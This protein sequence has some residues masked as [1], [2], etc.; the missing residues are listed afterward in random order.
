M[1]DAGS[2]CTL[3][4][5]Q[6]NVTLTVRDERVLR[7]L[8]RDNHE[9]DD[10]WL[11]DSGR[12]AYRSYAEGRIVEPLLRDGGELR[13]VSWERALH[14]A[15]I[16]LRRAG[17]E[18]GALA[19]DG[20]TNEEGLLLAR[21]LRE[22]L[23]S[24]HL[25]SRAP[26]PALGA[27]PG[28]C[29]AGAAGQG[30][31][32]GVRPRGLGPRGKP[33]RGRPDLGPATAQ[34]RAPKRNELAVPARARAAR[35]QRRVVGSLRD[36]RR[37][38]VRRGA[39]RS[40][41]PRAESDQLEREACAEPEAVRELAALLRRAAAPRGRAADGRTGRG[42]D[43]VGRAPRRRSRTTRRRTPCSSWPRAGPRRDRGRRA[44][45]KSRLTPTVADCAKRASCPT[46]VPG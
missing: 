3:C 42:C 6:C 38:A 28:A 1:E 33:G 22:G 23:G 2:V 41:S 17:A 21:L 4:P 31:R 11:C 10:G 24:P 35:R 36:G 30:L 34:G 45:W 43:P 13:A 14:E 37:C 12:F 32:P 9:V 46:P 26:A 39:E 16:R 29:R 18:T 19:G 8:A 20:S 25:D 44:C 7:V 27:A 15:A 40:T 5:A